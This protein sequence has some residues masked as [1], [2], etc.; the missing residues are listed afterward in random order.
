MNISRKFLITFSAGIVAAILV[1]L[2][3]FLLSGGY[4]LVSVSYPDPNSH[5]ACFGCGT[6]TV[7]GITLL[8]AGASLIGLGV[9]SFAYFLLRRVRRLTISPSTAVGCVL[10]MFG[11]VSAI[12]IS[13]MFLLPVGDMRDGLAVGYPFAISAL[14]AGII[15]IQKG[16][17]GRSKF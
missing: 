11:S 2:G 5:I 9:T 15:L 1:Y 16:G 17:R 3:M 4:H 8:I 14:V 6:D 13:S 12:F 7:Y 10:L